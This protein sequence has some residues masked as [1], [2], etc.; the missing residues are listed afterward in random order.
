MKKHLTLFLVTLSLSHAV[1]LAAAPNGRLPATESLRQRMIVTIADKLPDTAAPLPAELDA[2]IGETITLLARQRQ[3]RLPPVDYYRLIDRLQSLGLPTLAQQLIDAGDNNEAL[4]RRRLRQARLWL[5]RGDPAAASATLP[6]SRDKRRIQQ[7]LAIRA[8][9]AEAENTP[10]L[11]RRLYRSLDNPTPF[12]RFRLAR[13]L[14]VD[15][16]DKAIALLEDIVTASNTPAPLREHIRLVIAERRFRQGQYQQVV[17]VL[18]NVANDSAETAKALYLLGRAE[19]E[20]HRPRQAIRHWDEAVSRLPV[21]PYIADSLLALP[22]ALAS[23]DALDEAVK[24]YRDAIQ[25]LGESRQILARARARIE[26]DDW[27]RRRETQPASM[28]A[29]TRE[30]PG[31][32]FLLEQLASADFQDTFSAW[33]RLQQLQPLFAYL[34]DAES[35]LALRTE[36]RQKTRLLEDD[37]RQRLLTALADHDRYLDDNRIEAHYGLA[38]LLDRRITRKSGS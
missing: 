1:L 2:D 35:V 8:A 17:E 30:I 6:R 28:Q 7:T 21:N 25:R 11:A 3:Q 10:V 38:R 36:W 16:P 37:L 23:I 4:R 19:W 15:N 9:I 24:R 13:L 14:L 29:F 22:Y 31:G 32:P 27:L 34:S 33:W 12:D 20:N 26:Q 18:Q 5:Q